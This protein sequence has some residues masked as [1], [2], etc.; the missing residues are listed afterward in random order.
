MHDLLRLILP[1][2]EKDLQAALTKDTSS[3]SGKNTPKIMSL[4]A[5]SPVEEEE[6]DLRPGEIAQQRAEQK[7]RDLYEETRIF[8]EYYGKQTQLALVK[9]TRHTLEAIKRRMTSPS[10]I[11]YGDSSEEKKKLDHRSAIKVRLVLA[12]PHVGLKPTLDELQTSLNSTVKTILAVHKNIFMWGQRDDNPTESQHTLGAQSGV[13]SGAA[14]SGVLN[15]VSGVLS[16]PSGALSVASSVLGPKSFFK[17]ISENKEIAKLV[18]LMSTT[19]SSAKVLV[20]RELE[21]YKQYEELWSVDRSAFIEEFM[22]EE[23]S[24]SEFEAKMKE[25]TAMDDVIEEEE[26]TL[27][28]GSLALISGN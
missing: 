18:S 9:C 28:C 2:G 26:D 11:Q 17:A 15:A 16:A 27:D 14:Q 3:A 8:L 19:M 13:T 25:Y 7:K 20:T 24:L 4:A 22:K 23:P 10:A 5:L 12:I 1:E 6:E 21:R